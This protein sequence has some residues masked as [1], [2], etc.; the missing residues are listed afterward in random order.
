MSNTIDSPQLSA[1]APISFELAQLEERMEMTIIQ[2]PCDLVD[3]FH[4]CPPP[5]KVCFT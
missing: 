5:Y 4:E 2:L 3:I 1:A